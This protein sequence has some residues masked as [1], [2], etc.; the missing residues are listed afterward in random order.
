MGPKLDLKSGIVTKLDL[1]ENMGYLGT[2]WGGGGT[3]GPMGRCR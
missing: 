2:E 3:D 1:E